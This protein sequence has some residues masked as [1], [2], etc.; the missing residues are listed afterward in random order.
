MRSL[1]TRLQTTPVSSLP[2]DLSFSSK[3]S[4]AVS[5]TASKRNPTMK[6][7]AKNVLTPKRARQSTSPSSSSS[8]CFSISNR[9]VPRSISRTSR[10]SF[11]ANSTSRTAPN[12]TQR[13]PNPSKTARK[14]GVHRGSHRIGVERRLYDIIS[15]LCG[16]GILKRKTDALEWTLSDLDR[17]AGSKNRHYFSIEANRSHTTY[18]KG[19]NIMI[20][21]PSYFYELP[22][23]SGIPEIRPSPIEEVWMYVLRMFLQRDVVLV[24]DLPYLQKNLRFL[25]SYQSSVSIPAIPA[26]SSLIDE[27]P[28][29]WM[30]EPNFAKSGAQA[31]RNSRGNVVVASRRV[32][33]V[34]E[35][36]R[37][38]GYR[39]GMKRPHED[40]EWKLPNRRRM[41]R[42]H[43]K[44]SKSGIPEK[45]LKNIEMV[46]IFGN[47]DDDQLWTSGD[48]EYGGLE[49]EKKVEFLE[50]E[51]KVEF[52]ENEKKVEFLD[53]M[54]PKIDLSNSNFILSPKRIFPSNSIS[55]SNPNSPFVMLVSPD[56]SMVSLF[57]SPF[58]LDSISGFPGFPFSPSSLGFTPLRRTT[59]NSGNRG[60]SESAD[61]IPAFSEDSPF[62]LPALPTLPTI[63]TIP[64]FPGLTSPPTLPALPTLPTVATVATVNSVNAL[65]ALNLNVE[66][67]ELKEEMKE[68]QSAGDSREEKEGKNNRKTEI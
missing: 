25:E 60:N 14:A 65:N 52:L 61:A 56:R 11:S 7:P 18:N 3:N 43:K 9:A 62:A 50:N 13:T 54:D 20:C 39:G 49:N 67:E 41:A 19:N 66:I 28:F 35:T 21:L 32:A 46:P 17:T 53:L 4:R 16:L 15:V 1:L 58:R 57:P 48:Y 63:S 26:A 22:D 31:G 37:K 2:P 5:P 47:D 44:P 38:N 29:K 12:P 51:K 33:A 6:R 8:T 24:M 23:P 27:T 34:N 59:K 64:S 36:P 55:N 42:K 45:L 30:Q 10:R 68:K 40:E